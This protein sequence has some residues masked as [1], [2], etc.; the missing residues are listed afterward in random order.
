MNRSVVSSL[1]TTDIVQG[2]VFCTF[3]LVKLCFVDGLK[4]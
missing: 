4:Q 1:V 2:N 3:L